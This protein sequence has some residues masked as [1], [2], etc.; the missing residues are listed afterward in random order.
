MEFSNDERNR[1]I[2]IIGK[3]RTGK[4]TALEHLALSDIHAGNGIIFIDPHGEA[5]HNILDRLPSRRIEETCFIDFSD[6]QFSVGFNPIIEP[7]HMVTALIGIYGEK[8]SDRAKYYLLHGLQ[9]VKENRHLTILDLPRI[10][11]DKDFRDGLIDVKTDVA[12][13]TFWLQEFPHFSKRYNEEAPATIL[14]KLGQFAARPA[15]RSSL[16]QKHPKFDFETAIRFKQITIINVAKGALGDEP[17]NLI[18][19]LL[20]SHIHSIVSQGAIGECRLIIDEFQTAGTDIIKTI[21]AEDAKFGMMPTL[22]NQYFSQL[23][24]T[25]RDA[26]TGNIGTIVAFR[27][28]AKDAELIAAEMNERHTDYSEELRLQP[29][30]HAYI[31]QES[32]TPRQIRTEPARPSLGTLHRAIAASRRR[33]ARSLF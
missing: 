9:L 30:F 33:F 28:G 1:G 12:T 22:A 13:R 24:E 10:Y 23:P 2:Y 17:A 20:I 7:H 19:S 25:T 32:R 6:K 16:T 4:T 26:I 3:T 21:L 27:V 29:R 15:I 18:T 11:Y 31:H 14:N 8:V 5:S